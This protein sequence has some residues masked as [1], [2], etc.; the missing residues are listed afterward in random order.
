MS[1]TDCNGGFL[2]DDFS[3]EISE[4][5]SPLETNSAAAA[6]APAPIDNLTLFVGT[7][8]VAG[9]TPGGPG[10]FHLGDW[11]MPT[12]SPADM[13]VLG[14]QEIVRL[15]AGNVLG[16]EDTG[17]ARRWL[18]LVDQALNSTH[19]EA[20]D[21]AAYRLAASKQMVGVFLCVWV[22]AG[23]APLVSDVKVSCVRRGI[24]G[25]T[26][27]KGSISI[28][29]TLQRTTT[30]CFVCTHLASGEKD[31]DEL[32]RNLDV[33]EIMKRTRFPPTR[34]NCS[35]ETILEHDKIV[36]LGDLNYRLAGDT[37]QLLQKNDWRALLEK[38]QLQ[39]EK[40]AGRVF[41]GFE[42]GPIEFMPTYKYLT[43]SD[44]YTIKPAKSR[45][46]RRT[47][48]WCDRILWRGKGM[49][50][51]LYGRGESQ[52]SD[53]RP[54]YSFFSLQMNYEQPEVAAA[55]ECR[56]SKVG[57]GKTAAAMGDGGDRN[58]K[59]RSSSSSSSSSSW[60]RVQA[61]ELLL[62]SRTRS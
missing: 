23:L 58:S 27:N 46:K 20:P 38:D 11:L 50:Q 29:I 3:G 59:S 49:K 40:R 60:T 18:S 42:E 57:V 10:M 14:F 16:A 4:L 22:R 26:G 55:G 36:W 41:S 17:P 33:I 44:V 32:R 24:M 56:G 62:C 19:E 1:Y 47:P 5:E 2:S 21:S 7:W 35:P 51:V 48:A 8:N 61:E 28:S 37:R 30:L 39:I 43:N 31:G 6:T 34:E 12:P 52:F 15:S 45:G 13:F 25:C 53:H 9:R 54:V